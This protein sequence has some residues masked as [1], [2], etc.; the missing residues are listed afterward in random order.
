MR[1]Q[2]TPPDFSPLLTERLCLRMPRASDAPALLALYGDPRV[3]AH[4]SH[5][6]WTLPAQALAAVAEAHADLATGRALHLAIVIRADGA[7]AGS[8]ALFDILPQHRRATLGYLL[9]P[10]CWGRGLGREALDALIDY[11]FDDLRLAR[12]EAEVDP[13]NRASRALLTRLG[14]RLEG[15][16]HA[17]W[18]VDGRARDVELWALLR[19][20]WGA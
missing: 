19:R 11:G 1:C 8:C 16:L 7:L 3:M 9:A 17:R 20:D 12:I 4:W 15:V 5:A 14:F 10:D 18:C 2:M 13:C 6:P